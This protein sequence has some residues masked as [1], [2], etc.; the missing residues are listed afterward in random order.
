MVEMKL[1]CRWCKKDSIIVVE[2]ESLEA[3]KEGGLVQ[4]VFNYLTTSQ[5]EMLISRTC[6]DCFD[7]MSKEE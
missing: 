6:N 4:D 2:K 7:A 1:K 5:R 3:Y